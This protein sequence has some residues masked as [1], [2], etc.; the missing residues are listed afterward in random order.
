MITILWLYLHPNT[1]ASLILFVHLSLDVV[2]VFYFF[3]ILICIVF[4]IWYWYSWYWSI[5][6]SHWITHYLTF[7]LINKIN[8][9]GVTGE[10]VAGKIQGGVL[11]RAAPCGFGCH[12]WSCYL[13]ALMLLHVTWYMSTVNFFSLLSGSTNA[14]L[15]WY[16]VVLWDGAQDFCIS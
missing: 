4:T 15:V 13:C 11:G 5:I 16:I 10:T 14:S 1:L 7:T 9:A 12:T 3:K 6:L 2:T 8:Q